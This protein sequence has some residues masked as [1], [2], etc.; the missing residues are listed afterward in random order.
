M[1]LSWLSTPL[2]TVALVA[3][4]HVL[5]RTA[6]C[7]RQIVSTKRLRFG[8]CVATAEIKTNRRSPLVGSLK[9]P[10]EKKKTIACTSSVFCLCTLSLSPF[11]LPK[12]SMHLHS[13]TRRNTPGKQTVH[14]K[15]PP[16]RSADITIEIGRY[17]TPSLQ[18]LGASN[19]FQTQ[20]TFQRVLLYTLHALYYLGSFRSFANVR[21]IKCRRRKAVLPSAQSSSVES[22]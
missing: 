12:T 15:R 6:W 17:A 20:R 14:W 2:T 21:W 3:L 4:S 1:T 16:Q 10:R 22:S 5:E 9:R 19:I 18:V 11:V 7:I 13:F 8:S